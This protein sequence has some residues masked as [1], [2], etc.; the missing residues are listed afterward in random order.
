MV[1]EAQDDAELSEDAAEAEPDL[2]VA[3]LDSASTY[4][5]AYDIT[6]VN[7]EGSTLYKTNA[8]GSTNTPID[9]RV[10]GCGAA[11]HEVHV[12][13]LDKGGSLIVQLWHS[14]TS[15]DSYYRWVK[16]G[17]V[18][19]GVKVTNG[20]GTK[21]DEIRATEVGTSYSGPSS[22]KGAG[23]T[24]SPIF[25]KVTY[26]VKL[27]GNGATT[28]GT[29]SVQVEYGQAMPAITVPT[30]T[31]YAFSGYFWKAD[32]SGTQ[33]YSEKGTGIHI[34]DEFEEAPTSLST[35][36]TLGTL[37]AQWRVVHLSINA[38]GGK[39][40]QI[41]PAA[42]GGW[43]MD[44]ENAQEVWNDVLSGTRTCKVTGGGRIDYYDGSDSWVPV[45]LE[46]SGYVFAGWQGLSVGEGQTHE[47]EA[48]QDVSLTATWRLEHMTINGA[49]ATI[50]LGADAQPGSSF[51]TDFWPASTRVVYGSG[52]V[53]FYDSSLNLQVVKLVRPGYA[54]AGWKEL[55]L[56]SGEE[57]RF[58][59]GD[60]TL[61]ATWRLERLTVDGGGA[62]IYVGESAQAGSS[63]SSD[64]WPESYRVIYGRGQVNFYDS[65]L[66]LH[67]ITFK[68]PGYVFAGWKEK[69]LGVSEEERLTAGD[70]TLTATWRKATIAIDGGGGTVYK[71]VQTSG[72]SW[73]L[74]R[75]NGKAKW[76][77]ERYPSGMVKVYDYGRVEYYSD[78][79]GWHALLVER[80]GY[81]FTGWKEVSLPAG[82]TKEF[83]PGEDVA[84]TATWRKATIAIDGG[85]GT[86][87]KYV[88]TSGGSWTLDRDNGKA[89]WE[90]ERYP[91]GMVKVYDYGRVEYYSDTKGWHALLVERAGYAFV[92]WSRSAGGAIDED[93][94]KTYQP[95]EIGDF[96]IYA[97]WSPAIRADA[98]IS[99]T[100]R[101]D[102]LGVEDQA[103]DEEEPGYLESRCGEPLKVAEVSF[104]KKP[105]A[106]DLFGAHVPDIELQALPGKDA[107]WAT[108]AP[109]FSFALDAAGDAATEDDATKLAP[110]SMS[111]YEVRI[112]ISYR[113]LIPDA[114][115]DEVLGAIDPATFEDKKTPV[116]SVV[117]T[118]AL[119]NPSA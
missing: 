36:V 1:E 106:T 75:D 85:G 2:P 111:G 107:S 14:K 94:V 51:S 39:T 19:V 81:V 29:D 23:R 63:F 105:G 116:C 71:Y 37:Y 65:S 115:L 5:G 90:D 16:P 100:V 54:F 38:A 32:G 34:W 73:T 12:R 24:I 41:V 102:V 13:F 72:G 67:V 33:Y 6:V 109:A 26:T 84:L 15:D 76:E 47:F 117:Y 98:P 53:N 49:G 50:Y 82:G 62:T 97:K 3:S 55:A 66:N 57:R 70:L 64:L 99:A 110:L 4:A 101:L 30:R 20:A 93:L 87:Y 74:D 7:A 31:G 119:Q 17:Y 56:E 96:K 9:S 60:L 92:G 112:P 22:I 104:E 21:V 88:Q 79:K 80:T 46:R 8:S 40:V 11:E 89:K 28:M 58:D 43:Q 83:S 114:L 42:G 86:V 77:D 78:T 48:G 103:M 52:Q 61:T 44:Y 113:F 18:L 45:Q 108:D 25:E 69:H 59:F 35:V 10:I 118:V 68:H 95:S 27:D 91:S